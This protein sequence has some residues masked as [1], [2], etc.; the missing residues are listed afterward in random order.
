MFWLSIVLKPLQCAAKSSE[1]TGWEEMTRSGRERAC[2]FVVFDYQSAMHLWHCPTLI[3][4]SCVSF[5][6]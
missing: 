3:H 6:L 1:T 2:V 4:F 5:H